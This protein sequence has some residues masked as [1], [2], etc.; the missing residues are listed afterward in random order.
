[1]L[2]LTK[3]DYLANN[4]WFLFGQMEIIRNDFVETYDE[5]HK[6][7]AEKTLTNE[8]LFE[9]CVLINDGQHHINA[10]YDNLKEYLEDNL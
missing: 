3:H 4:I 2:R 9:F 8:K 5:L 1:M 10:R 6:D 7:N